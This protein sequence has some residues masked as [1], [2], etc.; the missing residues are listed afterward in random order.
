MNHSPSFYLRVNYAESIY[1]SRSS[2]E[3][4]TFIGS[5]NVRKS[6][7]PYSVPV[8]I[9]KII[10]D[11][12]SEPLAR[13]VNVSFSSGNFLEKLKLARITLIS[14]KGSRF[15]NY[16]DNYEPISVLSKFSRHLKDFKILYPLLFG[17]REKSSTM[18][19]LISITESIR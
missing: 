2:H 9:L 10:G 14:R 8:T 5:I 6:S 18:H 1:L 16:K 12:I 19:A 3:I 7:G 13:L 15:Y 17:F 11:Y 4:W